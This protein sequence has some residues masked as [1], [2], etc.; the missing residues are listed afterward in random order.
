MKLSFIAGAA[1][2]FASVIISQRLMLRATEKLDDQ[3]RL[4]ISKV[5]LRRNTRSSLIVLV[6]VLVS[7]F[8][9]YFWPQH[10]LVLV[11][12][13]GLAFGVY[14]LSKMLLNL[15]KLREMDI[16]ES[17]VANVKASWLVFFIGMVLALFVVTTV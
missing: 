10:L 1:I 4:R 7:L 11:W 5:F 13:C 6:V 12:I 14:L 3:T 8:A 17:Y 16:P 9:L 2:Y 15:R